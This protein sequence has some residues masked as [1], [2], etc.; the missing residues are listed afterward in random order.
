MNDT[1]VPPLAP[2][3]QMRRLFAGI[4]TRLG[5][6]PVDLAWRALTRA[7]FLHDAGRIDEAEP[8]YRRGLRVYVAKL[9]TDNENV[10]VARQNLANL[11][12]DTG[13]WPE[14]ASL[15]REALDGISAKAEKHLRV[16]A[17]L[18]QNMAILA[19]RREEW[20]TAERLYRDS[21][22]LLESDPMHS[23]TEIAQIELNFAGLLREIGELTE[24]ETLLRRSLSTLSRELGSESPDVTTA[25]QNLATLL[26]TTGRREEA[27]V[28]CRSSLATRE[29]TRPAGDLDIATSR[30]TL[31]G[32]LF[33]QGRITE[34]E[35]L[36][37]LSLAD[38]AAHK[39]PVPLD[40]AAAA[41]NLAIVLESR[42]DWDEAEALYRATLAT[43]EEQ[44]PQDHLDLA[45]T[46]QN[47]AGLLR[48]R[49]MFD[50]SS[51]LF[52]K[53]LDVLDTKLP[54]GHEDVVL[55]RSN[56]A[57]VLL[58]L[59]DW[60]NGELHCRE[61]LHAREAAAPDDDLVLSTIRNN[62][63][64]VLERK[65]EWPE[66]ERC[67]RV[68]LAV[69]ESR[70]KADHADVLATRL[71]LAGLIN[72]AGRWEEAETVYRAILS[73][74]EARDG[75]NPLFSALVQSNLA[76][77]LRAKGA[78]EEAA[79]ISR[80]ALLTRSARLGIDHPDVASEKMN[81]ANTLSD[82][83]ET[84]EAAELYRSAIA[85]LNK[86]FP[87]GAF[88]TVMA[89]HNLA[90][91]LEH[92]APGSAE[93]EETYR[94][95][96]EAAQC[97][98]P[99]DHP[100][101]ATF[102]RNY[103]LLLQRRGK[104]E[105]ATVLF[106]QVL[107][108]FR[109][110]FGGPS[111]EMALAQQDVADIHADAAEWVEAERLAR[112]ALDNWDAI[113]D[114]A[115]MGS[116]ETSRRRI[117]AEARQSFLFY[118]DLL[119][120]TPEPTPLQ[121]ERAFRGLLRRKGID[122]QAESAAHRALRS[123]AYP[124]LR[125]R[126]DALEAV[127][128]RLAGLYHA[129]AGLGAGAIA[130]LPESLEKTI[131]AAEIERSFL[132]AELTRSIPEMKLS[133]ALDAADSI[134]LA[135]VLPKGAAVVEYFT[136]Y[137]T[138]RGG[139]DRHYLIFVVAA[140]WSGPRFV[141]LGA[142]KAIEM[143]ITAFRSEILPSPV[144]AALDTRGPGRPRE[145]STVPRSGGRLREL[146]WDP[147]LSLLG[148]STET[149][150]IAPDGELAHLPFDLLPTSHGGLI[151]DQY[152]LSF[153]SSARDCFRFGQPGRSNGC[154]LIVANPAFSLA[155]AS[156]VTHQSDDERVV[157]RPTGFATRSENDLRETHLRFAPLREAEEEGQT[158][159]RLL[160]VEP[161][162]GRMATKR[163]VV[164]AVS[165]RILHLATHGFFVPYEDRAAVP[166]TT[167]LPFATIEDPLL[168]CGLALA[169]ANDWLDG[170]P[171]PDEAGN[172][173][174]LADD[175]RRMALF[176]SEL[177]VL[178]ACDTGLGERL[179]DSFLGLVRAFVAA[180]ARSVL[181]SLWRVDDRS[182]RMLMSVFYEKLLAG[183]SR[184][185]ALR[186]AKR[187]LR[188]S[189]ETAAPHHWA[190]FILMGD[191]GA[192]ASESSGLAVKQNK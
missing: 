176:D 118:L 119:F 130:G 80:A 87:E 103:A 2:R 158:L 43:Y 84:Q 56:F 191:P 19:E 154:P 85:V 23:A 64:I 134:G 117:I 99:D 121:I 111:V 18:K 147:V 34:A 148:E 16:I 33:D 132:E 192:S 138:A 78:W 13:R 153:V 96:V 146:V 14:A 59:G 115:F 155:E 42:G 37:R 46:R 190:G 82:M 166:G 143:A 4:R 7:E 110:R 136:W 135:G 88:D 180:G 58:E 173:L 182:T 71:N 60:R 172:G 50:D 10:A 164:D 3:R 11:L 127:T 165:P 12:R 17:L 89:Q 161:L 189:A 183:A 67:Y 188:E 73:A 77:L 39:P 181:V 156:T 179:G 31:A 69:R 122:S 170:R 93:A 107:A 120:R 49:G 65:G 124:G 52:R 144:R 184:A 141:D 162:A 22:S 32:F 187:S 38:F 98:V 44:L 53:A 90:C 8:L 36:Y 41:Q 112:A 1:P 92:D 61:A 129:L 68:S 81:L 20:T 126:L 70:L 45:G 160:G 140:G 163:H 28:L 55:A 35:C 51:A 168:R 167:A 152:R 63:G 150:F 175:V 21:L 133:A 157:S 5:F 40:V 105:A 91:L 101:L 29:T 151:G 178:S 100:Q 171:L 125:S 9:P 113:L 145:Q 169:G 57:T 97:L 54:P 24:S 106:K 26:W 25:Q 104:S 123:G 30:H 177:V 48:D 76:T 75:G 79:Q 131:A 27:E 116:S 139:F 15:Y 114:Q 108:S 94:R 66:A 159:G 185:V 174:L 95:A 86:A 109:P 149:I 142:A 47:L 72:N 6:D 102:R 62:L 74:S 186:E 128:H 83:G 137:S